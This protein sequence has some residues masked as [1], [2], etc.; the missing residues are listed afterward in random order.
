MFYRNT[1]LLKDVRIKLNLAERWYGIL[2]DA[3]DLAREDP[4]L[5]FI[6]EDVH[7]HLKVVLYI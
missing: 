6:F 7:C 1:K 4:D 3:I 5:A 2:R